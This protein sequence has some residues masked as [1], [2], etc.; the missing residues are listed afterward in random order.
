M[1]QH[2]WAVLAGCALLAGCGG[3]DEPKSKE[4][5]P[6]AVSD[7]AAKALTYRKAQFEKYDT[8]QDGKVSQAEWI[9]SHT[10]ASNTVSPDANGD[11]IITFDE[12]LS[13]LDNNSF[14]STQAEPGNYDAPEIP[15]PP[16]RKPKGASSNDESEEAAPPRHGPQMAPEEPK[17]PHMVAPPRPPMRPMPLRH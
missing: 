1:R 8:D 7:F 6:K 2:F 16:E 3:S 15:E 17:L 9:N 14:K 12:F 5:V 4:P 13:W 11:G 10:D